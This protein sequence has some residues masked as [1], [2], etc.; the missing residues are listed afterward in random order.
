MGT[1]EYPWA[2]QDLYGAE[3][4]FTCKDLDNRRG[5]G[6]DLSLKSTVALVNTVQANVFIQAQE[7]A[8]NRKCFA[9]PSG[10][11]ADPGSQTKKALDAT[12]T[13]L[14]Q[15]TDNNKMTN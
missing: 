12:G 10:I 2:Y 11:S 7:I 8:K 15:R 14:R 4:N 6:T 9:L 5:S 13:T 3:V 1:L